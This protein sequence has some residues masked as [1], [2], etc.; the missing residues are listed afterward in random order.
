MKNIIKKILRESDDLGW[1]RD[2]SISGKELRQLLLDTG[3][4]SIPFD[5]VSGHLN[6]VGTKIQSLGNLQSVGGHLDL[7]GTKIQSLG[8]L[9]SVGGYLDLWGT[10]IQRSWQSSKRGR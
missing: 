5:E 4:I 2:N 10:P 3:V 1:M 8:N 9:Q 6:L 7:Y